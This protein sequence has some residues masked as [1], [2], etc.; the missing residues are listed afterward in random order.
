MF[1]YGKHHRLCSQKTTNH[2]K[3]KKVWIKNSVDE[4]YCLR[5]KRISKVYVF[6]SSEKS[7]EQRIFT[8]I[9]LYRQTFLLLN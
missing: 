2:L 6:P 1:P 7:A 9:L 8:R 4:K 3:N 5:R